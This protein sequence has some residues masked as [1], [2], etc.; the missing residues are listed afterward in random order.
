M[1]NLSPLR[2]PGGKLQLYSFVKEL[3]ELNEATTHIE[4]FAGG[5]SVALQL[6]YHKDVDRIIV[7]DYD[8]SVYAFWYSLL[9]DTDRLIAKIKDTPITIDEWRRQ[10][11]IQKN[12]DT[13]EDLLTLG[14]STFFLNRTN[15]SGI[16]K[17]G[18]IGGLNQN[19]AYKMDC[20]FNKDALI[21]KIKII[22]DMK[23]RIEL[24]N[25]DAVDFLKRVVVPTKKALTFLDPPYYDKGPGLYP[26]FYKDKDHEEL[27]KL[28]TS[29]LAHHPWFLTYDLSDVIYRY[30]KTCPHMRYYLNYSVTK[31]TK[32][33]EYLF[34]SDVLT[35]NEDTPHLKTVKGG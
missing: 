3:V 24:H 33:V 17:A 12:K 25:K 26:L 31:P 32:G 11:D 9:N 20:R 10:K 1:R 30:Y 28:L 19:G 15:R 29:E 23:D 4:P 5:M 18:V 8:K 21:D 6:L 34:Y 22:A 16:L 35:I 27:A 14:F 2:Y 7:N 13:C